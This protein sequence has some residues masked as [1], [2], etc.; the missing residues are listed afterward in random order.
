MVFSI[1]V[2][3]FECGALSVSWKWF[4]IFPHSPWTGRLFICP[5]CSLHFCVDVILC[6]VLLLCLVVAMTLQTFF[7]RWFCK[8]CMLVLT[9]RRHA[10]ALCVVSVRCVWSCRLEGRAVLSLSIGSHDTCPSSVD[11]EE[12]RN[13][14]ETFGDGFFLSSSVTT[15]EHPQLSDTWEHISFFNGL[16]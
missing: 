3:R 16:K 10:V 11:P 7:L 15:E 8:S 1:S 12:G 13:N 5:L 6:A 14:E 2:H 9:V 4:P